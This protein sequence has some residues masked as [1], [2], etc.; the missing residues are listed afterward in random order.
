MESVGAPISTAHPTFPY[1]PKE[2]NKIIVTG[3]SAYSE[4][5]KQRMAIS[6]RWMRDQINSGRFRSWDDVALLRNNWEGPLILKGIQSVHDAEK[7]IDVGANGIVVSN[8]GALSSFRLRR[9]LNS[10][11]PSS[12][13]Y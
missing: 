7:A 2:L 9:L 3:G 11:F 4:T 6:I 5:L 1:D 10:L 8:H 13:E 12:F